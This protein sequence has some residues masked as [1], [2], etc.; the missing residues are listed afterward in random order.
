MKSD[1][2]QRVN[3]LIR[4]TLA[5]QISE[6]LELPQNNIITITR[7]ITSRDLSYTKVFITCFPDERKQKLIALLQGK[8][9]L[10]RHLLANNTKLKRVPELAFQEDIIEERAE[11]IESVLDSLS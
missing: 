1:R 8:S 9:K 6:T 7:V 11:R 4:V 2:M 10:L 5:T 3:E